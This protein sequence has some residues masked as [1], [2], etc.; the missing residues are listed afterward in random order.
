LTQAKAL[1]NEQYI[2]YGQEILTTAILSIVLCAPLGAILMT[3]FGTKLL[4]CD[5]Q[6]D[7]VFAQVAAKTN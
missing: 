3:T 2:L 6:T 4:T 1:K 5:I 7:Q